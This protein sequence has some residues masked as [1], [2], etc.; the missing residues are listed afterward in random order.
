MQRSSVRSTSQGFTLVELIVVTVMVGVM[1]AL[2]V[3]NIIGISNRYKVNQGFEDL[4][5]ALREAQREAMKQSRT[6]TLTINNAANPVTVTADLG[7]PD[8]PCIVNRTLPQGV[9]VT[10]NATSNLP[11]VRFSYRGNT[12]D[13][14]TAVVFWQDSVN[15]QKK[16]V[17]IS[18]G[19]GMLRSGDFTADPTA[20]A[21]SACVSTPYLR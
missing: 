3:P 9:A 1:A 17:A 14:F 15:L 4:R 16:C 6:C 19:I 5:Q 11:R 7:S 10:T 18:L 21:A 12:T 20:P 13:A 2:V 8:Q